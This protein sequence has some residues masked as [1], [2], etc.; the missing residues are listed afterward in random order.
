MEIIDNLL[1]RFGIEALLTKSGN[2]GLEIVSGDPNSF[3]LVI[4]DWRLDDIDGLDVCLKMKNE[5]KIDSNKIVLLS[6]TTTDSIEEA[7]KDIG[8]KYYLHKPVNPSQINDIL[9][10][11]FLGEP[12]IK[13]KVLMIKKI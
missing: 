12:S 13:K 1:K 7:I 9:S 8:I 11:I 2:D 5:L 6:G 3:D 4:V 10:E